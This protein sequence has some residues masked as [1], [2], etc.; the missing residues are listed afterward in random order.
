MGAV[1]LIALTIF[2]GLLAVSEYL[3]WRDKR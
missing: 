3:L 1:D 2:L